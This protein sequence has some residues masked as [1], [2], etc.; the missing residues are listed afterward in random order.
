MDAYV[1]RP[2]TEVLRVGAET[3]GGGPAAAMALLE[4]KLPSLKGRKLYGAFRLLA[5]GEECRTADS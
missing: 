2:A 4:S 5:D 1:E 3:K